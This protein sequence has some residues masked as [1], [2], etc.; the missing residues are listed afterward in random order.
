MQEIPIKLHGAHIPYVLY[1][2]IFTFYLCAF[3]FDTKMKAKTCLSLIIVKS[4][5]LIWLY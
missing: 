1:I 5:S 3:E 2:L 4:M